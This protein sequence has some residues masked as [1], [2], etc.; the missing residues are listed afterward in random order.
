MRINPKILEQCVLFADIRPEDRAPMLG[1]LGAQILEVPKN[2][3]VFREGDPATL[4]GIVLEGCV[5][6]VR[7]DYY[8]NRSILARIEPAGLFGESFAC[9]DVETL[10]ISVAAVDHTEYLSPFPKLLM[11]VFIVVCSKLSLR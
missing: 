3:F 7:E 6:M 5:Q 10:P 1:C 8:G 9:A 4:V 11:C 2:H